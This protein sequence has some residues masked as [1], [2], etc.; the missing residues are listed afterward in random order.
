MQ[1]AF[2]SSRLRRCYEE[3]ARAIRAW[4]AEV[5]WR[6]VRR[7]ETLHAMRDFSEA[8]RQPSWRT[9][10]LKGG[11]EGQHA[12]DLTGRWRLIVTRGATDTEV[13]VEEVS[14]HYE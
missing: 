4:G 7:I 14:N 6:Y 11:R 8:F 1:V 9:H 2:G 3:S 5:G 12:I 13:T 10:P